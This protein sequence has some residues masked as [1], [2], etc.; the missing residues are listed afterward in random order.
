MYLDKL[1]FPIVIS[2]PV[3]GHF[4]GHLL[5]QYH[6]HLKDFVNRFVFFFL[7]K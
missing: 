6:N 7:L 1:I 3:A 2:V 5:S 4:K